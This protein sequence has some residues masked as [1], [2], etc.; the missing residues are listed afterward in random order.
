MRQVLYMSRATSEMSET[1]LRA[2]LAAS[3]RNNP[4]KGLTGMLLYAEGTFFQIL[5]GAETAVEA[6]YNKIYSDPRHSRVLRLRET[7]I[8]RRSFPGWSMGFQ[9]TERLNELPSAFFE[10][11]RSSLVEK[12]P[13]GASDDILTFMTSFAESK[14]SA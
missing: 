2:I 3:R 14:L 7:A 13:S 9:A 6:I 5:E 10:L 4:A 12:I 1:Q 8:A 11:S